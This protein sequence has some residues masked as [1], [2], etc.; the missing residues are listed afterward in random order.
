MTF[1]KRMQLE[2]SGITGHKYTITEILKASGMSRSCFYDKRKKTGNNKKRG[3]KTVSSD[4]QVISAIKN[5]IENSHFHSEGYKKIHKRIRIKNMVCGKNRVHR[6]MKANNLLAPIRPKKN[7]SSRKHD[8]TIITDLPN[9]M[10]GTDGKQFFT[11]KEGKCWFFSVIDHFNDEIHGFDVVKKGDR[12]AAFE[13][14]KKAIKKEYGSLE[15]GIVKDLGLFLRSDH[16]S[17]YDSNYFQ[18]EIKYP[19]LEYSPAFVRSPEC[20]GIIERF[21]RTLQEQVFDLHIF[22]DLE[23]ARI[24]IGKFIKN[25]NHFWII[26]R[27]GLKSPIEYRKMHI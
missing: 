1:I 3:P 27:L 26:H 24:I 22:E 23:E 18:S 9:K 2:T 15:K 13:P 16:G 10:W 25:Y 19:G 5:D 8:G 11:R 20:N 7:G 4:K 12:F 21:H 14:V 6:L 17:Q